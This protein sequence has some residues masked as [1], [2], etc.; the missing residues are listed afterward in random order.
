MEYVAQGDWNDPEW[1]TRAGRNAT[2]VH[3]RRG[4]HENPRPET[5]RRLIVKNRKNS[6]RSTRS[7]R[8]SSKMSA[9]LRTISLA[10]V[11]ATFVI[12]SAEGGVPLEAG[13]LGAEGGVSQEVRQTIQI[14]APGGDGGPFQMLPPGRQAKTGTGRLR[15][16]V[17][18]ADTG[19]AVRRAQVRISGP[20][21]GSKTALTDA[22]G[23][24][25]F[26]DLPAGRFTVSVSKAGFVAM[27]YG[28]NRPFE[29][30][31]A[32]RSGRG[33]GD[34]Q[35]GRLAAARQRARRPGRRRV[36]RSGCRRGSPGHANAVS[37]RQAAPCRRRG[38]TR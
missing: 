15:G 38:A 14:A 24:Y 16:R 36:R 10:V 13:G 6:R 1:L 21:I 8:Y 20:D 17:V 11:C 37:E 2:R 12:T 32:D 31:Q 26:R 29:N 27:Q 9:M 3:A 4:R 35:G 33:A 23:R 19:T 18:A 25:E 34:G 7:G 5:D 28:Q 30:R 22:Q